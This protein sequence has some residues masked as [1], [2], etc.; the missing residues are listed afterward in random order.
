[1]LPRV[2]GNG[3][4]A[5]AFLFLN[6]NGVPY[7]RREP[8][9]PEARQSLRLSLKRRWRSPVASPGRLP[10]SGDLLAY[11][12]GIHHR[13]KH[14]SWEVFLLIAGVIGWIALNRW[15]LPK[16]GVPT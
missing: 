1:M 8:M 5:T 15:V 7:D 11:N 6:V 10:E 4:G 16:L 12:A 9:R 14:M 13:E 3:R 2:Q